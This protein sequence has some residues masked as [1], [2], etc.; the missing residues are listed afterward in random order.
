VD[1][2]L[3]FAL[4]Y[5]GA[6]LLA[7]IVQ[8]SPLLVVALLAIVGLGAWLLI[9]RRRHASTAVAVNAWSQATCPACLV[10][11]SLA[12]LETERAVRWSSAV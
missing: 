6:G 11:G 4:G 3:H 12:S 7:T 8:P 5:A 2:A 10:L 9:A 1:L